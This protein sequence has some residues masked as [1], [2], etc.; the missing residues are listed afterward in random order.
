MKRFLKYFVVVFILLLPFVVRA[1]E[2]TNIDLSDDGLLTFDYDNNNAGS[3]YVIYKSINGNSGLCSGSIDVSNG[4]GELNLADL[5]LNG[6]SCTQMSTFRIILQEE[7]VAELEIGVKNDNNVYSLL[8]KINVNF[9]LNGGTMENVPETFTT[10]KGVEISLYSLFNGYNLVPGKEGYYFD[11]FYT[12]SDGE[13]R[14]DLYSNYT[15]NGDTT[16]YA[17]WTDKNKKVTIKFETN[18][19]T[20][21][22][23]IVTKIYSTL[24]FPK[25]PTKDNY[26]FVA[27]YYDK[28]FKEMVYPES[29]YADK[30]RTIYAKWAKKE[31][32]I[33]SI[34]LYIKQ[35][36][37]GDK[38]EE[39]EEK[40]DEY[41]I[42]II[43][44]K[45]PDVYVFGEKF[46]LRYAAYYVEI[47]YNGEKMEDTFY[48]TFEKDKEYIA[49]VS[50]ELKDEY[51]GK[52]IDVVYNPKVIVNDEIADESFCDGYYDVEE[53]YRQVCNVTYRIKA[54]DN[55]YGIMDGKDQII[56]GKNPLVVRADGDIKKFKELKVDNTVV[57]PKNYELTEGSTIVSLK[58]SYLDS[59][60]NGV[61]KLTFVYEDGEVDT[62][63]SLNSTKVKNPLTVDNIILVFILIFISSI[64]IVS[65][66][67][68]R[69]LR[70]EI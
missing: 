41:G 14:V 60:N 4:S 7:G 56:D 67:N 20:K 54:T 48:G 33:D 12:D 52:N 23:D 27:W 59:L 16:L 5:S 35:P 43:Q 8:E 53:N 28:D 49:S 62:T 34:R 11:G 9:E 45:V 58:P 18:G 21:V 22:E 51:L 68:K 37:I 42:H 10:Y 39:Y 64:I 63:F 38:V 65:I 44:S 2:F 13:N 69:K 25:D 3:I 36:L 66:R 47:D 30:D 40:T 70:Y 24:E 57:D 55:K 61:H 17:L 26:V 15:F 6:V 50:I 46:N 19:G 31:N 29:F 1:Y 32:V